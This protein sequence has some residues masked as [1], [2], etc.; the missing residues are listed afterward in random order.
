MPQPHGLDKA[1]YACFLPNKRQGEGLV[2]S[3]Q[4]PECEMQADLPRPPGGEPAVFITST[5]TN[6]QKVEGSLRLACMIA[7]R[8]GAAVYFACNT[9]KQAERAAEMASKL[10]PD[11]ERVALERLHELHTSARSGLH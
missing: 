11:H 5:T 3:L 2:V 9:T 6:H 8:R 1:H 7:A 4:I 10:L